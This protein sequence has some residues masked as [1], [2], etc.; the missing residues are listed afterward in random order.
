MGLGTRQVGEETDAHEKVGKEPGDSSANDPPHLV[1]A[2]AE[3][4]DQLPHGRLVEE[5]IS[6]ALVHRLTPSLPLD[7][8]KM[9]TA[10]KLRRPPQLSQITTSDPLEVGGMLGLLPCA[11]PVSVHK[12]P[13]L[14]L[15]T[16]G[17]S[18]VRHVD[19]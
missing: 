14:D 1:F 3:G 19:A 6:R 12:P 8:S 11:G 5:S 7:C 16:D 2:L 13:V 15:I 18:E 9:L 10:E 4:V 17:K